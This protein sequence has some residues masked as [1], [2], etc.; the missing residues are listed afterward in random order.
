M[1]VPVVA[2]PIAVEGMYAHD[3]VDCLVADGPEAF[4][5]RIVQLHQDCELWQQLAEGGRRNVREHFSVELAEHVFLE[6]RWTGWLA[7]WL[8]LAALSR[9]AAENGY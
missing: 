2:T 5:Q 6:V 9:S 8:G 1:G 3:G 4:A 7:G